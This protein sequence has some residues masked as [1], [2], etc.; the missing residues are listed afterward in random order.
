MLANSRTGKQ[1]AAPA[2]YEER[3]VYKFQSLSNLLESGPA[4]GPPKA[5]IMIFYR[6]HF[7][8]LAGAHD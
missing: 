7:G 4:D 8:E 2:P 6:G 5:S 3:V 1:K